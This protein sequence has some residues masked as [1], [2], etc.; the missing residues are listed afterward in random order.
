[1][2]NACASGMEAVRHSMNASD[3][4]RLWKSTHAARHEKVDQAE[5]SRES[6]ARGKFTPV[7]AVAGLAGAAV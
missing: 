5:R 3:I 2:L 6:E 4:V 1:M 7:H